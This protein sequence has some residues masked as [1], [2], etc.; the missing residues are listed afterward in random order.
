[1]KFKVWA[2][3]QTSVEGELENGKL[4]F[5]KVIPEDRKK[6]IRILNEHIKYKK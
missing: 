6:D 3:K 2:P 5:L 4:R 1:V